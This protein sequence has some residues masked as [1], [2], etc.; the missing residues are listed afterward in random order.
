[1][2]S[3]GGS[4]QERTGRH[5]KTKSVHSQDTSFKLDELGPHIKLNVDLTL[6]LGSG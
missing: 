1:M 4:K 6:P 2:F 5:S 3:N